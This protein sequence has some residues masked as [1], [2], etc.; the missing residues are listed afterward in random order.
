MPPRCRGGLQSAGLFKNPIGTPAE[1]AKMDSQRNGGKPAGSRRTAA[2]AQR[3][4]VPHAQL[5]VG[6]LPVV[7]FKQPAID[8]KNEI[9]FEAAHSGPHR[10]RSRQSKISRQARPQFRDRNRAPRRRHQIRGR[11]SPMLRAGEG[12]ELLSSCLSS[13]CL[14]DRSS[15]LVLHRSQHSRRIRLHD[16]RIATQGLDLLLVS[17]RLIGRNNVPR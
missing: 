5:R 16:L 11:D 13:F 6:H 4:V 8:A 10:D 15:S 9:V 7:R 14:M 2:H 12:E 3:D 1:F 17:G